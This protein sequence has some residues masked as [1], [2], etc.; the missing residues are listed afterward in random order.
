MED[1]QINPAASADEADTPDVSTE[2]RAKFSDPFVTANGE[3]RG[4]VDLVKLETL[5]FN[6]GTLCNI[7]CENCYIDSSPLND[8]L[9]YLTLED[10]LPFL[11]EIERDNLGTREIGLTGGE[12][13]MN[14]HIIAIMEACLERG[15]DLI[16]LTN[17]MRPMMRFQKNLLRLNERFGAAMTLRVS[18]DHYEEGLHEE[19]RGAGTWKPMIEGLTWLSKNGF[20]IDVA[21]RTRWNENEADLRE[22]F[23]TFFARQGIKIDASSPKELVLFPEM[24]KRESVPEITTRCWGLLGIDP[25]DIMCAT[26]RMIVKR[27]GQERA[28]VLACTLIPYD[29]RFEY[30]TT[31]AASPKRIQLNHRY[32]SEFCVTGGGACSVKS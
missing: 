16:V 30:D 17:A 28:S 2:V 23:R 7:A 20:Q 22:G 12:P 6:T 9:S 3:E 21:G 19:E 10:V 31:L 13:F 11:E 5:W 1:L 26:S 27:K 32:C 25:A 24:A 14:R 29:K 8:R 18:V 15:F 4:F